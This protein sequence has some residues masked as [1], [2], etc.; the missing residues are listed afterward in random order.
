MVR[1]PSSTTIRPARTL[2][3]LG[4]GPSQS[5]SH[6]ASSSYAPHARR[7]S[8]VPSSADDSRWHAPEPPGMVLGLGS[9]VVRK[10]GWPRTAGDDPSR[11]RTPRVTDCT[12]PRRRE[13]PGQ[14]PSS[15]ITVGVRPEEPGMTPPS[16]EAFTVEINRPRSIEDRP[17]GYN[18]EKA[19][20]CT[21]RAAEDGPQLQQ[22]DS[23]VGR[24]TPLGRG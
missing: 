7:W 12:P 6:S 15:E 16:T 23:S 4:D 5:S 14:A 1:F 20:V 10:V 21:P 17:H 24:H 3:T 19:R 13:W 9:Y 8:P 18:G 11:P 2:R 22:P